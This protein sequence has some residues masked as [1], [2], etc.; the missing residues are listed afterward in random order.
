MKAEVK[1]GAA[2]IICWNLDEDIN[3]FKYNVAVEDIGEGEVYSNHV[4]RS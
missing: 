1:G 4:R 2:Y 3:G